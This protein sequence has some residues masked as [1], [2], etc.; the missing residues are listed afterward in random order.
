MM[1]AEMIRRI[2]MLLLDADHLG[3]A[4]TTAAQAEQLLHRRGVAS[5]QRFDR[6]IEPVAHPARYTKRPRLL[7]HPLA[8]TD[9]LDATGDD[10][11][12]AVHGAVPRVSSRYRAA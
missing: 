8:K 3:H 4:R 9:T 10:Q 12:F 2:G 6:S 7:D 1:E 5:H 11:A